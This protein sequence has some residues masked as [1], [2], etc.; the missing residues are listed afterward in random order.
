MGKGVAA[1]ENRQW[2]DVVKDPLLMQVR[3]NSEERAI[4]M[5]KPTEIDLMISTDEKEK[6]LR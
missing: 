1:P 2:V 4:T 6:L 5:Q 3:S